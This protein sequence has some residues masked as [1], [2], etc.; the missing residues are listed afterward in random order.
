MESSDYIIVLRRDSGLLDVV[1]SHTHRFFW[2]LAMYNRLILLV[3]HLD[4]A[5]LGTKTNVLPDILVHGVGDVCLP[6]GVG[7][8]GTIDV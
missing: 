8:D 7:T 3:G 5:G 1:A 6:V 4:K 2:R